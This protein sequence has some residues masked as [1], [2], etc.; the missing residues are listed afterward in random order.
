MPFQLPEDRK[1]PI[2]DPAFL[3]ALGEGLRAGQE[4]FP[5]KVEG[6]TTLPYT[7]TVAA[8]DVD[9]GWWDLKLQRALPPELAK[10]AVFR[11]TL[12][13]EDQR[14]E[15]LIHLKS[16]EGYLL[17]RFL[18]PK[19][20][21]L[22]DRRRHK[23][24]ALRP[25]ENVFV[26]LTDGQKAASGP[27]VSLSVGGLGFRVDRLVH[28]ETHARL[29]LD[30]IHFQRG[31]SFVIR[32][33]GLPKAPRLEFRGKVA[34]TYGAEAG[35]IVG[36]EFTGVSEEAQAALE[37]AL[38]FREIVS[39]GVATVIEGK[40]VAATSG[41]AAGSR[42]EEDPAETPLPTTHPL[43]RLRRRAVPL[44]LLMPEGETRA[45]L[46]ED[47]AR[48]GY[49]RIVSGTD[50][51]KLQASGRLVLGLESDCVGLE[52]S[53]PFEPR[54]NPGRLARRLDAVMGLKE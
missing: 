27:M 48:E 53:L 41:R 7:S 32:V 36:L 12:S 49:W 9:K 16:R 29:P 46:A 31:M 5:I 50:G 8:L 33:Q 15:G 54:E 37:S 11:A 18:L 38:K 30:T 20:V 42:E 21:F 13:F 39:R 2:T 1:T 4:E 28:L 35:L 25:R 45:R 23:R 43:L 22:A 3:K 40:D 6:T 44:A 47:L 19:E 10:G 14:F 52:G 24:Y 51:P 34:G 26:T 17:Y